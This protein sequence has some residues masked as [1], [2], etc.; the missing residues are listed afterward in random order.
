VGNGKWDLEACQ[1]ESYN[2]KDTIVIR[3]G[4]FPP[5][6][7]KISGP[8]AQQLGEK[9][10]EK[11]SWIEKI[12]HRIAHMGNKKL[13]IYSITGLAVII[14]SYVFILAP[15]IGNKAV[16][17]IPRS[18]ERTLGEKAKSQIDLF[19]NLDEEKS[20]LAQEFFEETGFESP[21]PVQVHVA[22]ESVV[23]AF[24][25]P[26]GQIVIY[27]GII[28]M[29][30]S[31]EELAALLAHELAHVNERHSMKMLC[32]NLSTYLLISVL[33]ADV[34][35]VSS[36]LMDNAARIHELS[37][38]RSHEREA[39]LVGLDYLLHQQINPEAMTD[40]FSG[41]LEQEKMHLNETLAFLSSHPLTDNRID[42]IRKMIKASGQIQTSNPN[43][44][45]LEILWER[46]K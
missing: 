12:Y 42:Y 22:Q 40:L 46:L 10:V 4:D 7:L 39:D 1:I 8:G 17:L 38:S 9:L 25:L 29:M 32:R 2:S 19:T 16:H 13:V 21:Y 44:E 18:F 36:I 15:F 30:E 20:A 3:Y 31:W 6:T 41:F 34:A 5:R 23:N 45:K 37:N 35:G 27:Q 11:E 28:D 24:A 43:K 26:G 14:A 33:T